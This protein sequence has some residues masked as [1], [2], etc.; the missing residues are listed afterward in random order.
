MTPE[1]LE[2]VGRTAEQLEESGEPFGSVFYDH[3]FAVWPDTRALF[4]DDLT[5]QRA[6]LVDEVVYLAEIASD[7]DGFLERTRQL[8]ARHHHYGVR[9]EHYDFVESALMTALADVLGHGFTDEV[10]AAWRRLYRLVA[11]TMME[12]A[13]TQLYSGS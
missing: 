1:Q 11:E 13:S 6:K 3:L 5:A 12:G 2:L 9:A 8:G 4:P 10:E 7:L